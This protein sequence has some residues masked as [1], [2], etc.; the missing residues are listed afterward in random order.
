MSTPATTWWRKRKDGNHNPEAKSKG[1]DGGVSHSFDSDAPRKKLKFSPNER[2]E[3]RKHQTGGPSFPQHERGS[4]NQSGPSDAVVG[5]PFFNLVPDNSN[6]RDYT[7]T[8]ALSATM[9]SHLEKPELRT[10][11]TG[12]IGRALALMEVDEVCIYTDAPPAVGVAPK[13]TT[14]HFESAAKKTADPQLFLARVLQYLETPPYLRKALFPVHRDLQFAGLMN[15]LEAPHHMRMDDNSLFRE[16]VTL[17][18][19]TPNNGSLVDCGMRKEVLIDQPIKPGVRVTVKIDLSTLSDPKYIRA[20]VVSPNAPREQYGLYWGFRVRL[21]PS[22]SK[23]ILDCPYE[24]GY[25]LTVGVSDKATK[26]VED[27]QK[28]KSDSFRTCKHFLIVLG[29][30]KGIEYSLECDEELNTNDCE[31]LFDVFVNPLNSQNTYNFKVE[32]TCSGCSNA[33][34]RILSKTEGVSSF[35]IS[36]EKKEV[37]V[38]TSTLS[39]DDVF[40]AIAKSGKKVDILA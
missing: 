23:V 2:I 35:D 39:Q 24:G 11:V 4:S 7:V 12:Q 14:G 22:I 27:V 9:I 38:K 32:M 3:K 1:K 20:E 17:D 19:K 26:R 29:G 30:T 40:K 5:K 21:A 8:V 37:S 6:A 15:P 13:D 31:E 33:V 16:G 28:E 34:Q 10:Y 36:L 18:T 25:D